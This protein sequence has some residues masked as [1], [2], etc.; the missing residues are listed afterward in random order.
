MNS[1]RDSLKRNFEKLRLKVDHHLQRCGSEAGNESESG[2]ET[3]RSDNSTRS[4]ETLPNEIPFEKEKISQLSAMLQDE[5][6]D[7]SEPL[8]VS[9]LHK[10]AEELKAMHGYLHSLENMDGELSVDVTK[11][12]KY[13]KDTQN[14]KTKLAMHSKYIE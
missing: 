13:F 12:Y 6:V 3:A 7:C 8:I 10:V 4:R 9:L 14:L 2:L 1:F 11:A 5:I